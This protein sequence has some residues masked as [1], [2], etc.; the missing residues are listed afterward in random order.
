MDQK[1]DTSMWRAAW[2]WHFYASFFVLPLLFILA[3]TGLVILLKPTIERFAYNDLLYVDK[4]TSA[5]PFDNQLQSV[6]LEYPKASIDAVVPPRD[7]S[8]SSQFDITTEDGT[9]RSVYVNPQNG[10]VLGSINNDTRIDYVATRIH[11]T[12]FLGTWGDYIIEMAAGWILVMVF[13]GL[14][15][16]WPRNKIPHRL[17]KA[18][19]IRIKEKG[20]RRLRDFHAT[21]GALFAPVLIFLALTGL[22]WSGFWG[23]QWGKFIDSM[24]SGYNF[25]SED[26]TSLEHAS[27][28]ETPGLQISW[29]N[30]RMVIPSSQPNHSDAMK[31]LALEKIVSEAQ[32]IGMVPGYAIG[33]PADESG[34][35]TLSNAWPSPAHEERTVY[36]D[37]YSGD[38]LAE[39]G[40]HASYG[41]LAKGTAW[42]VDTHMGRQYGLVNGI[43]MG[44]SCL[45]AIG[46]TITAPMMF[47]RRRQPGKSGFP[48][49]PIDAKLSRRIT[50]IALA[51]GLMF[52]LLGLSMVF[53]ALVDHIFI[54]RVPQLKALFGMRNDN[55]S[56]S[57]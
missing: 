50:Y 26:P 54:R 48:R 25:P 13:T 29:A 49:R 5:V 53:M 37:Q 17:R 20:R 19:S 18:F 35:Y 7:S 9:S 38:V 16:W 56:G 11:G 45:A 3:T 55:E 31:P 21:P 8:R 22:P 14:Y 28:I 27:A 34:V 33:L 40:W 43:L 46:S 4:A 1:T 2:R 12:L 52:P 6:Q 10:Q 24:N 47:W 44:G 51:L 36:L 39:A 32:K 30:E 15:L 23:A 42:G 41:N 57:A